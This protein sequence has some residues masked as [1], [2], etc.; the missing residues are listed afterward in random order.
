MQTFIATL[1]ALTFAFAAMALRVLGR[2]RRT[3]CQCR[4]AA[5]IMAQVHCG[6]CQSASGLPVRLPAFKRGPA[7]YRD[8]CDAGSGTTPLISTESP[9]GARRCARSTFLE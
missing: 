4:T 6:N 2:R 9:G 1:A 7:L 5:D 8:S 3:S